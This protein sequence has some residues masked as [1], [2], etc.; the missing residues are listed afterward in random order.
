MLPLSAYY[1]KVSLVEYEMTALMRLLLVGS[2]SYV[3][4]VTQCL[5]RKWT[6]PGGDT[7]GSGLAVASCIT[8]NT[9]WNSMQQILISSKINRNV[10][11]NK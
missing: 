7:I 6:R 5:I 4:Q 10:T 8:N 3:S 1:L 11:N 2:L 9:P